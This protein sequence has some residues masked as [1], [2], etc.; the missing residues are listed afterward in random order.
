MEAQLD[1]MR[2]S[3]ALARGLNDGTVRSGAEIVRQFGR[4]LTPIMPR[5]VRK[6]ETQTR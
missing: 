4:N 5:L 3:P 1:E 6:G 2:G